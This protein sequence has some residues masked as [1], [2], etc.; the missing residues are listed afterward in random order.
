VR[1]IDTLWY[2]P[3]IRHWPLIALLLPLS[4][5][6]L[7]VSA[8]RRWLYRM[9]WLPST[10]LPV[11]VIVVGN[12]TAGGTGKT[13][14]VVWLVQRLRGLGWR[15]GIVS[16]GYGG[17][18]PQWPR[19]V[20]AD[21]DPGVVGDEPVLLAQRLGCP[22]AVG[23]SRVDDALRLLKRGDVD[24]IVADDGLQHYALARDFE[25][26]VV[27]GARGLGN[28]LPLPAGPLREPA[29]RLHSV[30]LV[31]CT[32]EGEVPGSAVMR[33]VPAAAQRLDGAATFPAGELRGMRAHAVA[34]I[35]NPTR[36]FEMLVQELG[37]Q[38]MPHAFGDH[39]RF[40]PQ[41]IVFNDESNVM[42][43]EKDAVKCRPFA[44]PKHW[45]VPVE[46]QL[47]AETIRELD[48]KLSRL[49][50]N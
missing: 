43:T 3:R 36:F 31:I 42:M 6:Y 28:R 17:H 44:G 13:P 23:P 37:M 46:A 49:K 32:G 1:A 19:D 48:A 14:L 34:G 50:R 4:L 30:D 22:I 40:V 16:R 15:P 21:S 11:P 12:I 26:A 38:V 25:I 27:D 2:H 8:S 41:D 29:S 20:S 9:G 5:L 24:V 45:F 18:S 33:L 35:G 47:P 39:H 10:Q 7:L